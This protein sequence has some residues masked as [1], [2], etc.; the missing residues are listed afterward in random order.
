[1]PNVANLTG[2][3]VALGCAALWAV[4]G[5][6][7]RTQLSGMSPA[8]MN[9]VRCGISGVLFCCLLPFHHP[10]VPMGQVP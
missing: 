6:V 2:E 3:L 8:A 7:L 4:N 9:A 1:V 5:M 10:L